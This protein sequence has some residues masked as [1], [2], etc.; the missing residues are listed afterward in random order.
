MFRDWYRAEPMMTQGHYDH[1]GGPPRNA[2]PPDQLSRSGPTASPAYDG[3]DYRLI[4]RRILIVE[5]EALL[6]MDMQFAFEDEGVEVIGPAMSLEQALAIV[7]QSDAIDGAV[8]DVDL[9]G[10]DVYPV[11]ARL[12]QRGVPLVFHTGHGS[13]MGHSRMFPGSVT[14]TKPTLPE[15]LVRT[16]AKLAR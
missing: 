11:A 3:D 7:H 8:L 16:L 5:D 10:H 15:T 1:A 12:Q 9:N 14:C 13:R 2:G 6:A 4:G